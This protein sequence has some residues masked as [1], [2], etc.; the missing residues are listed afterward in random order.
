MP[1]NAIA[2]IGGTIQNSNLSTNILSNL[3]RDNTLI[4]SG[5]DGIGD[6][7][8][9]EFL[10]LTQEN[11]TNISEL[12]KY[13]YLNNTF[14]TQL[15]PLLTLFKEGSFADL[16][17]QF[18]TEIYRKLG[19]MLESQRDLS[20]IDTVDISYNFNTFNK[21]ISAF[22]STLDGFEKATTQ[23]DTLVELREAK[24]QC[25]FILND[26]Q[27]LVSFFK[28][29]YTGVGIDELKTEYNKVSKQEESWKERWQRQVGMLRSGVM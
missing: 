25:D 5:G 29:Q 8:S 26:P 20:N 23:S 16:S 12:N 3:I 4:P 6:V 15:I 7:T 24:N 14:I 17:M 11:S 28:Q 18:T 1:P 27:N 2:S 10:K 22:H 21:Y 19:V 13:Q 9:E